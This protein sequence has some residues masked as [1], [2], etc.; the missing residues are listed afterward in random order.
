LGVD[1]CI[2]HGVSCERAGL[3]LLLPPARYA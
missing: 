3:A 2:K 1:D